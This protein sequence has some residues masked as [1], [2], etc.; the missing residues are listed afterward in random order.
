MLDPEFLKALEMVAEQ[1]RLKPIP[2]KQYRLYYN[3]DG[4]IIGMWEYDHPIGDNFVVLDHPDIFNKANTQLMRVVKGKLT[5]LDP[6]A[7]L[8]SRL[9]R[10]TTGQPVVKNHPAIAL[11]QDEEYTDVE[12]YDRNN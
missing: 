12:H 3:E 2:F 10:S 7:P 1:E 11:N 9:K 8:K 6:S 5:Q 4:T